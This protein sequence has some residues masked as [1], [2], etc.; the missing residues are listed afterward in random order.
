VTGDAWTMNLGLF[1]EAYANSTD[2]TFTFDQIGQ[3]CADRWQTSKAMNP[4]FY[5]GPVTGMIVR[6]AGYAFTSR[7]LSNHTTENPEG[8]LSKSA[9]NSLSHS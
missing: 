4:A 9:Q 1:E 7:L 8:L 6:N 2:G 3:R 5:Y